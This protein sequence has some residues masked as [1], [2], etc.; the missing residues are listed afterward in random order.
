MLFDKDGFYLVN[1]NYKSD[2][3]FAVDLLNGKMPIYE[4][5]EETKYYSAEEALERGNLFPSLYDQYRDYKPYEI[6][7][8][9]P[10]EKSLLEIQKLDFAINELNLYLDL[11]PL[12]K[13]A[14]SLFKKYVEECARKKKEYSSI[15]GP[16]TID[17]ITD[18]YE[19]ASGIWPWEEGEM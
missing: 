2:Y 4:K 5:G 8:K 1:D 12:D 6:G 16:L 19:W 17:N 7:V 18:E 11:N 14:Y 10:R 13:E 15:Y 9:T 3:D